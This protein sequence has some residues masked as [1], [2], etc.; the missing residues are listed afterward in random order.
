L[1]KIK[2]AAKALACGW[3]CSFFYLPEALAF[4]LSFFCSFVV[5]RVVF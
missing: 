1:G 2:C 4:S 5:C 3:L